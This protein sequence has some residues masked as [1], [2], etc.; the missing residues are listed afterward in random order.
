MKLAQF[1]ADGNMRDSVKE[2]LIGHLKK[3]VVETALR[4]DSTDGYKEAY[5]VINSAFRDL[6]K[7]YGAKK[8]KIVTSNR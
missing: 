8:T 2:F 3:K 6:D 1:Y 5:E 7:T 4:G